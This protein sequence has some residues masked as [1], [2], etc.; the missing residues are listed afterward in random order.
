MLLCRPSNYV[1]ISA[2]HEPGLNSR[3]GLRRWEGS[4][5]ALCGTP[6]NLRPDHSA[7]SKCICYAQDWL[8]GIGCDIEGLIMYEQMPTPRAWLILEKDGRRTEV[9]LP[10]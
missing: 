6:A 9:A 10:F 4:A 8:T 2:A 3:P 5:T 7:F 1:R